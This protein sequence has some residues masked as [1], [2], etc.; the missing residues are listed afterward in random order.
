[1]SKAED[2]RQKRL[3][4]KL[5]K[6]HQYIGNNNE[7]VGIQSTTSTMIAEAIRA[8]NGKK[9]PIPEGLLLN[10]YMKFVGLEPLW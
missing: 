1:M 3:T 2:R 6:I 10:E 4:N 7:I 5:L 8:T 9:N